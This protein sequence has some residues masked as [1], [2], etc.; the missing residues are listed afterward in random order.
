MTED[1]AFFLGLLDQRVGFDLQSSYIVRTM[2][3]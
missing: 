2:K 1:R 3:L